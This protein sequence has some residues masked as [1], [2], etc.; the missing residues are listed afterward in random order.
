M[1]HHPRAIIFWGCLFLKFNVE[2]TPEMLSGKDVGIEQFGKVLSSLRQFLG[3][4]T[5]LG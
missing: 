1:K 5:A 2:S 4:G 3:S